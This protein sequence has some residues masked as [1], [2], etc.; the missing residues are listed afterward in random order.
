MQTLK[1][2]FF[3]EVI[4]GSAG[5]SKENIWGMEQV[6]TGQMPNQHNSVQVLTQTRYDRSTGLILSSS[7]KTTPEV[8]MPSP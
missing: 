8:K 7:I 4:P 1:L 2:A 6:F 3:F 5:S